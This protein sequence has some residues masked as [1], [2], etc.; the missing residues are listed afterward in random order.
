MTKN[1][2]ISALTNSLGNSS[3]PKPAKEMRRV[4]VSYEITED[5]IPYNYISFDLI[6]KYPNVV[7]YNCRFIFAFSKKSL[8]IF[9]SYNKYKEIKWNSYEP[10]SIKCIK[11][12]ELLFK[13]ETFI[14][15]QINKIVNGFKYFVEDNLQS[16]FNLNK[17]QT[18]RILRERDSLHKEQLNSLPVETVRSPKNQS[19]SAYEKNN[20]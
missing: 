8:L 15:D 6:P 16:Q 4:V 1:N 7:Q 3:K 10:E 13:D 19:N 17:E 5:S 20:I 14:K 12:R 2:S 18:R 11:S 9:Y